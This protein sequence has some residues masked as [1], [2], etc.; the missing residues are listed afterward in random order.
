MSAWLEAEA[1]PKGDV[2][3]SLM[4]GAAPQTNADVT[5]LAVALQQVQANVQAI[6]TGNPLPTAAPAVAAPAAVAG[7]PAGAA[8]PAAVVGGVLALGGVPGGAPGGVC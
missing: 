7:P 4:Q 8:P 2:A 1:L 5:Q 3:Y 6:A